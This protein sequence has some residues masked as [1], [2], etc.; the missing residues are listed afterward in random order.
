LLLVKTEIRK[1]SIHGLGLFAEEFIPEGKAVWKFTPGFDVVMDVS[2]AES[3]R[4]HVK[5]YLD[6]YGYLDKRLGKYILAS[7]NARFI[8]HSPD[9]NIFSDDSSDYYGIDTAL[10]NIYPGDEITINYSTIEG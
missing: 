8:N 7:D 6:H 2:F 4:S 3:L 9:P 5:E 10:R 1:S